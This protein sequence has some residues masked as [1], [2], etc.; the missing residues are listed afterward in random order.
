MKRG[1]GLMP[2]LMRHPAVEGNNMVLKLCAKFMTTIN[3]IHTA[4]AQIIHRE[5]PCS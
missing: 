5:A 2:L 4:Q 3:S 1:E